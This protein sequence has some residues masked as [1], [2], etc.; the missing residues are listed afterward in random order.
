MGAVAW[1][2]WP[3]PPSPL[4]KSDEPIS[5]IRLSDWL[6]RWH[7]TGPVCIENLSSGVVVV[8]SGKD[9]V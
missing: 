9:G 5:G 3:M 8:K 4:I 2:L 6:H 1:G 7:T